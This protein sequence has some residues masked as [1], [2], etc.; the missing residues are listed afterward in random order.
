MRLIIY[1]WLLVT[2]TGPDA[3][4]VAST[5]VDL[6][7]VFTFGTCLKKTESHEGS[8]PQGCQHSPLTEVYDCGTVN[9]VVAVNTC[10]GAGSAIKLAKDLAPIS[11][12]GSF[13]STPLEVVLS[14]DDVDCACRDALRCWAANSA[15]GSI[16]IQPRLP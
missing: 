1:R 6:Q 13:C 14:G 16:V 12:H 2:A 9:V 11:V 7:R 8:K 5:A 3:Q 15:K 10:C 4:R